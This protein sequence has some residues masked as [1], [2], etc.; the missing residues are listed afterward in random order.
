MSLSS[1]D[2]AQQIR[3][4]FSI[5]TRLLWDL[6]SYE[7][8]G[9]PSAQ[10]DRSVFYEGALTDQTT[11]NNETES[12]VGYDLVGSAG[13]SGHKTVAKD[14]PLYAPGQGESTN[15]ACGNRTES[16]ASA[17]RESLQENIRENFGLTTEPDNVFLQADDFGRAIDEWLNLDSCYS[18][19]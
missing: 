6:L 5:D 9:R 12:G 11:E 16:N 13:I 10:E 4:R 18:V 2:S 15:N 3:Q 19:F 8:A 1:G 14:T 17:F 7:R